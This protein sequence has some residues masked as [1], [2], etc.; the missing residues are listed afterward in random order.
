MTKN[1]SRIVNLQRIGTGA[2][3]R[4]PPTVHDQP[5][6]ELAVTAIISKEII[7]LVVPAVN[8]LAIFSPGKDRSCAVETDP[9]ALV[10]QD[11]LAVEVEVG[12]EEELAGGEAPNWVEWSIVENQYLIIG[13]K[14]TIRNPK[15]QISIIIILSRVI[16]QKLEKNRNR[17]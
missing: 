13:P 9:S 4:V 8:V 14:I 10:D 12:V 16:F 5:I 17:K 11:L 2:E 7:N 6:S 15:I 3:P 1:D